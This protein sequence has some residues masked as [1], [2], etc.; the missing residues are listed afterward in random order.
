MGSGLATYAVHSTYIQVYHA[1]VEDT[2]TLKDKGIWKQALERDDCQARDS[3]RFAT[4]QT[5]DIQNNESEN[6]LRN[7]RRRLRTHAWT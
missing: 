3:G 1:N 5:S 7:C 6:P 4:P 2:D